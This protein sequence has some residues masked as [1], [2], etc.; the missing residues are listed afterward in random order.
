MRAI[1]EYFFMWKTSNRY[2]QHKQTK[3]INNEKKLK[4]VFVPPYSNRT[5]KLTGPN[6]EIIVRY[7]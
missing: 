1:I 3:A 7:C 5:T 2:V 6:G 4:Q